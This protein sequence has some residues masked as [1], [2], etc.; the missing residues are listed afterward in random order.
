MKFL[1]FACVGGLGFVVD[2]G[3]FYLLLQISVPPMAARILSFWLAASATWL[4]NRY[5]TFAKRH[6]DAAFNQWLKHM[7]SAHSSGVINLMAF[8]IISINYA[9]ELAFLVGIALGTISNYWLSSRFVF[10][11]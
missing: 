3:C 9:V 7:L 10:K 6:P 1:R 11:A 2:A 4:G 8:Y 5:F